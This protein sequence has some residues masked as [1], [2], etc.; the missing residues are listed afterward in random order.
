MK[1]L[2]LVLALTFSLFA[3]SAMAGEW[4]GAISDS[5]CGAKHVDGSEASI[6]CVQG[7]VKGGAKAVFVTAD[8]KV[9]TI[10]NP[11]KV[12]DHLGHKVTVTGDLEEET[13]TIESVKHIES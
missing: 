12:M 9:L 13:L 3:V 10:A 7:C 6:K 1:K 5:K 11:D 4:T 8:G 2:S